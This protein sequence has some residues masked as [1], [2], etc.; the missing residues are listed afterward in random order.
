MA[1]SGAAVLS[2]PFLMQLTTV[3]L[4]QT[5]PDTTASDTHV[6]AIATTPSI[7]LIPWIV[8]TVGSHPVPVFKRPRV[9][10]SIGTIN[11]ATCFGN[12][13]R[14]VGVDLA[15][16]RRSQESQPRRVVRPLRR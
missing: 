5:Q 1:R 3:F 11:D 10:P 16:H 15:T 8:V 7:R 6:R 4:V 9:K 2:V 13:E 14:W 12:K